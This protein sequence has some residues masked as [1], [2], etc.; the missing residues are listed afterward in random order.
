[1]PRIK[2]HI[3]SPSTCKGRL[4]CSLPTQVAASADSMPGRLP[5][6][7]MLMDTRPCNMDQKEWYYRKGS[8][9]GFL[10]GGTMATRVEIMV[11]LKLE[12][13]GILL[14]VSQV[15]MPRPNISW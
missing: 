9:E 1:M 11:S 7:D 5:R 14:T 3:T 4:A 2:L 6:A 12:M 15:G 13:A 10:P 8:K